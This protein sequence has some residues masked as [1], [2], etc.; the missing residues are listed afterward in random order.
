M[1]NCFIGDLEHSNPLLTQKKRENHQVQKSTIWGISR[2]SLSPLPFVGFLMVILFLID[3]SNISG[4]PI[5]VS[6]NWMEKLGKMNVP[7]HRSS[8]PSLMDSVYD[9]LSKCQGMKRTI[10]TR[11][12][13]TVTKFPCNATCWIIRTM[14][15]PNQRYIVFLEATTRHGLDALPFYHPLD[16]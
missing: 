16:I 13:L 15:K 7:I 8:Q 2:Q 3:C 5:L 9:S 1:I 4:Q 14:T 10:A 6:R 12:L 11:Y